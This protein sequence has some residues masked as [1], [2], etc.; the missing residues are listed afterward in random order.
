[1]TA[2]RLAGVPQLR[3]DARSMPDPALLVTAQ[4]AAEILGCPVR[5]NWLDVIGR[6]LL[7][8]PASAARPCLQVM[9]QGGAL[10]ARTARQAARH[11]RPAPAGEGWLLGGGSAV[12]SAGPLTSRITLTGLPREATGAALA[13]LVPLV[14]P[15]LRLA[16]GPDQPQDTIADAIA[17]TPPALWL[18]RRHRMPWRR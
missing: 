15:R 12:L 5:G 1:V 10:A 17:V 2:P 4:E 3:P 6:V 8:R 14:L 11:G 9:V 13:R 16:A 18:P 7:W